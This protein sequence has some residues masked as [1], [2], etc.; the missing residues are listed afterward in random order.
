MFASIE[1]N[2]A[3]FP[4]VFYHTNLHAADVTH[5]TFLL[6]ESPA[7]A[8][9]LSDVDYLA[10]ILAAAAH[11]ID[12]PGVN[13]SFLV[14]TSDPLATLYNDQVCSIT[15]TCFLTFWALL[16]YFSLCWRTTMLLSCSAS[17]AT[18]SATSSQT[19]QKQSA[20]NSGTEHACFYVFYEN[21]HA[22]I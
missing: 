15:I 2:Y 8:S 7:L 19:F 3:R 13:N 22:V 6:M 4:D 16:T 21:T 14:N 10:A 18:K 9:M 11:D 12:H 17:L 1:N 20:M 5:S